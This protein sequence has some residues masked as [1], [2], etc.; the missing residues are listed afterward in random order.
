MKKNKKRHL[1]HKTECKKLK[2]K[3]ARIKMLV[4]RR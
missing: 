1:S 4:R 3:L 2:K